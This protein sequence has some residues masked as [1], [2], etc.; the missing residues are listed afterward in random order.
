MRKSSMR[1]TLF[2]VLLVTTLTVA[3]AQQ[4]AATAPALKSLAASAD[5]AALVAKAKSDI[6]PG[7]A[8]LSQPLL[9]LA[10]YSVNVEYRVGVGN[11]A[12]H[13]REAEL[14]YVIDGTATIVTGGQLGQ[15]D[16]NQRGKSHRDRRH[17][18]HGTARDERRLR[19]GA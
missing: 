14:F 5:V 1:L 12:V 2:G 19:A 16:A 8:L 18:R 7:Q 6:K 13:E 10:P 11:A 15:P 9:Q 3:H 4:P 17:R